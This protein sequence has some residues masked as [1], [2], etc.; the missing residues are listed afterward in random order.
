MSKNKYTNF[1]LLLSLRACYK[2]LSQLSWT[3]STTEKRFPTEL[4]TPEDE[5]Q[6][7]D[8]YLALMIDVKDIAEDLEKLKKQNES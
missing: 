6:L 7:I 8:T 4:L 2:R 3:I 1:Q 5:K